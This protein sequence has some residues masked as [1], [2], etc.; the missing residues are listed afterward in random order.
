[1]SRHVKYWVGRVTGKD[2]F[3]PNNQLFRMDKLQSLTRLMNIDNGQF[4]FYKHIANIVGNTV[5]HFKA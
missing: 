3:R 2:L 5:E 1:M 4:I